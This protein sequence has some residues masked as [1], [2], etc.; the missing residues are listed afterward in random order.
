M[1]VRIDRELFPGFRRGDGSFFGGLR[2]HLAGRAA[3]G[4]TGFLRE[5]E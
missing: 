5:R 4:E 1:A 2:G 3:K